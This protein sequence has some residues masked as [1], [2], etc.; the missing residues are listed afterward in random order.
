MRT[1]PLSYVPILEEIVADEA[2]VR[3]WCS[4]EG[5]K[6]AN[7]LIKYLKEHEPVPR[8]SWHETL[9][10]VARDFVADTG[11]KGKIG[12][13]DTKGKDPFKRMKEAG[14]TEMW[15]GGE[16]CSYG[17][18]SAQD[19]VL[20]LLLDDGQSHRGHRLNIM[21][22]GFVQMG[23]ASGSHSMFRTMTSIDYIADESTV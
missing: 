5:A 8:L 1:N 20:Q 11:P 14:I 21:N 23:C 13:N 19:V 3:H 9:G 6:C 12:H 16:N 18:E 7:G 17:M 10:K 22:K 4:N 15:G 2:K